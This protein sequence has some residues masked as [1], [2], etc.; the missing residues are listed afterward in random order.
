MVIAGYYR[1]AA[2]T[3]RMCH[4]LALSARAGAV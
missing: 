3:A 2:D 1:I 4:Q